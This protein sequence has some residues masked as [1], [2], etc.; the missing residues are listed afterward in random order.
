VRAAS[1]NLPQ[2]RAKNRS[3]Y[4]QLYTYPTSKKIAIKR[5]NPIFHKSSSRF[6]RSKSSNFE[7][8]KSVKLKKAPFTGFGWGCWDPRTGTVTEIDFLLIPRG[9]HALSNKGFVTKSARIY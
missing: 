2:K 9:L 3:V 1:A 6:S 4:T 7:R 5:R 8:K